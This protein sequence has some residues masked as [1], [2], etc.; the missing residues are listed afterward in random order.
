MSSSDC[1]VV[2]VR[3]AARLL[4]LPLTSFRRIAQA[5]PRLQ[6]CIQPGRPAK[7]DL[8]RLLITWRQLEQADNRSL[9]PRQELALE[10]R[11]RLWWQ[12]R[13]LLL[14]LQEEERKFCNAE[15]IQNAEKE[16]FALLEKLMKSWAQSIAP[17]LLESRDAYGLMLS[18]IN[19][20]LQA[21]SDQAQRNADVY[22]ETEP[23]VQL[24]MPPE[25]PSQEV[26]QADIERARGGLHRLRA[27]QAA[28][29]V[30]LVTDVTSK[31]FDRC[32][33]VRDQFL[34][35]APRLSGVAIGWRTIS[36]AKTELITGVS[37]VLAAW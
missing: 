23:P 13:S 5:E 7:V 30:V 34:A 3:E 17:Q 18:S 10:R 35:L 19:S 4:G 8:K 25:L 29:E 26:L 37:T 28:G 14:Q 9:S 2:S 21:A 11:K 15:Q 27:Q 1:Q 6:A 32:R 36:E 24:A 33:R 12:S 31:Q 16:V 20:T 22:Q